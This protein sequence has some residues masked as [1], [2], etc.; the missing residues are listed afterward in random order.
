MPVINLKTE[1]KTTIENCFDLSRNVELHRIST[2]KTHEE[3]IA[4]KVSG[5]LELNDW[6]T[7]RAI[8]FGIKPNLTVK[9][10]T[11]DR[12][13]SFTDLQIHGIFK[14]FSHFHSFESKQGYVLMTDIFEYQVPFGFYGKVFDYLILNNYMKKFLESRNKVIK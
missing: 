14:S 8:H 7:W 10:T 2:T 6:V 1:I 3:A 13:N 11:F 9:I 4:G 5:L 12:P